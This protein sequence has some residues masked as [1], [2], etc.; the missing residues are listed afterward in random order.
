VERT[1]VIYDDPQAQ[2]TV[3]R[4][5]EPAGY[6][7]ITAASGPIAMN[8]SRTIKPGRLVLDVC[9][10]GRSGQDLCCQIRR[11]SKNV[12]VLVLSA[13]RDVADVVLLLERVADDYILKPFNPCGFLARVRA[14]MRHFQYLTE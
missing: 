9:L 11:Q 8:V 5:L 4:I 13:I 1:L 10:P 12:P 6:D 3:R 14:A 7:V 2:W